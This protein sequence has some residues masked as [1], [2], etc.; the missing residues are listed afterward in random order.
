MTDH[1][2]SPLSYILPTG[3]A[4]G[5]AEG[6]TILR[7]RSSI[8]VDGEFARGGVDQPLDQII[9]LQAGRHWPR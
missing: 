8:A 6:G 4:Y 5:I 2:K 9:G 3:L 7:R 1:W